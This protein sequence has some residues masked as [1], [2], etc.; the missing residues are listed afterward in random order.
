MSIRN[1]YNALSFWFE[2]LDA[3]LVPR[4]A[5]TRDLD[6]DVAIAGAGFTGLWTAYYLK[7]LAPELTIAVL[8]AEIAGFGASGRNGGWLMSALE[9]SGAML[10]Q[11]PEAQAQQVRAQILG[12]I[13]EVE[14]VLQAENIDCD[15]H[16]GGGL[17]AA[18]RFD[19]QGERAKALLDEL[20]VQGFGE[21]DY[22][23]LDAAAASALVNV[24][25]CRGGIY[26]P[27]IATINPAKLVRAL[28]STVEKMGVQIFEQTPVR[29]IAPGLLETAT[30][31]VRARTVV[32]ALEGYSATAR[33]ALPRHT[34]PVASKILVTEPLSP[35]QWQ[36]LGFATRPAF[37]DM[38]RLISYAQRTTD[39][40][41]LFGARGSY[42]FGAQIRRDAALS[43]AEIAQQRRYLLDFFPALQDA[44][45]THAWAGSLG[46]PRAYRPHACF[47]RDSGLALAGGYV[48]EGVGA[49]N[50]MARTLADLILQ[51]DSVLATMPWAHSGPVA[52]TLRHW[53]PEPLRW[54]A[55]KTIDRIFSWEERLCLD[56]ASPHWKKSLAG[57]L[58]DRA[59]SFMH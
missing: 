29:T 51:R 53:E 45:I 37:S 38:S 10:R 44:R 3:P 20:R 13:P 40:R 32:A 57:R 50:L 1:P 41:L 33:A 31:K 27:H 9:G 17:F 58:A 47:D 12:I 8:E 6:V 7:Q 24:R 56:P 14:R 48:G 34:I 18:A 59:A 25:D 23:W 54:L 46:I 5:L 16:R 22:C 39:G 26:T 55:Y 11:L 15:F 4:A 30:A 35:H 19:E 43:A 42:D 49:A 52:N 2:R 21:D 28:A 36:Q